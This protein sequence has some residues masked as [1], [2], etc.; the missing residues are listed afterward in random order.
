MTLG[1]G[2]V[3][4]RE[5]INRFCIPREVAPCFQSSREPH[6]SRLE[7]VEWTLPPTSPLFTLSWTPA[8]SQPV[9]QRVKHR[10]SV[11]YMWECSTQG[12]IASPA[13][14]ALLCSVSLYRLSSDS[15]TPA[16]KALRALHPCCQN[17][18]PCMNEDTSAMTEPKHGLHTSLSFIYLSI[19]HLLVNF[20]WLR[21]RQAGGS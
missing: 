3:L 20:S 17:R 4:R 16:S 1:P 9:N 2:L 21:R 19:R 8:V 5:R 13:I 18:S 6:N 14:R 12:L 11:L 10:S 7:Q 15:R